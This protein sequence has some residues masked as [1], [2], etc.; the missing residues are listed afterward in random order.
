MNLMLGN[1][2]DPILLVSV[3]QEYSPKHFDF[4]VINGDWDG[5]FYNGHVTVWHPSNPW[6]SLEKT[7]ILTD[8]QDRLRGNYTEV[9]NNFQN[10][11]YIAPMPKPF[12]WTN[13]DDDI[14]F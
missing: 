8:N 5:S 1:Q 11:D 2:G 6:T 13:M 12:K 4:Y 14:P 3:K 10:P 7:E 9:F